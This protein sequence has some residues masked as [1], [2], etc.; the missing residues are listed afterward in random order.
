MNTYASPTP[1]VTGTPRR[2]LRIEGL[3]AFAIASLAF[4]Q[5]GGHPLLLIP[6]L[7]AVDVS[8]AGYLA[9]PRVGA[10]TYNLAHQ[11]ATGL[12]VLAAGW[13]L[14]ST[15]L[16]LAG[17]VLVAHVGMDRVAGYGGGGVVFVFDAG[18]QQHGN[19]G[20]EQGG[21]FQFGRHS[22]RF[23]L[24]GHRVSEMFI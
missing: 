17:L 2:W 20:Q 13:W 16:L 14:A 5:L 22:F 19:G 15:P 1:S 4:V 11:W 7:L 21:R 24:S 3:A 8:M 9:N 12:V 10:F 18:L 6:L 23:F